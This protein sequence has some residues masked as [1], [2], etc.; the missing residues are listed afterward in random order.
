MG[1]TQPSFS[2]SSSSSLQ[3]PPMFFDSTRRRLGKKREVISLFSP[4]TKLFSI[5]PL[6][7]RKTGGW[8]EEENRRRR[9]HLLQFLF[10][11]EKIS[12]FFLGPYLQNVSRPS[13]STNLEAAEAGPSRQGDVADVG[14]DRGRDRLVDDQG[15]VLQVGALGLLHLPK[16]LQGLHHVDWNKLGKEHKIVF[17]CF[18]SQNI[19]SH[20]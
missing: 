9:K 18:P 13:L 4:P 11:T 12:L 17:I 14:R 15:T 7:A 3:P 5:S 8:V 1:M 2:L 6:V 16:V 19:H 20:V 10:S